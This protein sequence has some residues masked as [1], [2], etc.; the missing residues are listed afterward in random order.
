MGAC[1]VRSFTHTELDIYLTRSRVSL[2][3]NSEVM[4]MQDLIVEIGST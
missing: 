3:L 2:S 1:Q 4:K